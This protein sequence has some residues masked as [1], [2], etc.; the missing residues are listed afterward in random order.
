MIQSYYFWKWAKNDLPG[1]PR[2]VHAELLRG[3]M[4][5]ALQ[6]FS[7]A[8]LIDQLQRAA[9]HGHARKEEWNWQT[10]SD[11][12]AGR[13]KFVFVTC[14]R[15]VASEERMRRFVRLFAKSGLSGCD[16]RTGHV[17][18]GLRPKLNVFIT[19]QHP[20]DRVY[21]ISKGDLP[22]LIRRLD[23]RLPDPF[24]IIEDRRGFFVQCLARGRRFCVE[25]SQSRFL[26]RATQWD[27]W[28]AQDTK[29]LVAAG[30]GEVDKSL[31]SIEKTDL[32]LYSD[33][34]EIFQAFLREEARPTRYSWRNINHFFS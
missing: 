30:G 20:S 15:L 18:P 29:R 12:V 26:S 3:R 21:D 14:P 1:Q 23:A 32:L 16:E 7:T 19:G 22:R 10:V 28:R 2:E 11:D 5:P 33:T 4:H 24:G 6:P 13:A 8:A 27:Q 31:R 17:I 9:A 34:L 25:W